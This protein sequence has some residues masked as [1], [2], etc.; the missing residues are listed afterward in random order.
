[1]TQ[2]PSLMTQ[3]APLHDASQIPGGFSQAGLLSQQVDG[4]DS[5]AKAGFCL[6]RLQ[7]PHS[8]LYKQHGFHIPMRFIWTYS[9]LLQCSNLAFFKVICGG[10]MGEP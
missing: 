7:N 6:I 4:C 5:L 3:A 8:H 2:D 1:M 9:W 10:R